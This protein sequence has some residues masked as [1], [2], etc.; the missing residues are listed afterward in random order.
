MITIS[1]RVA[2][3]R[4]PGMSA[5]LNAGLRA[6]VQDTGGEVRDGAKARS[7]VDT[8]EMRAGWE[9]HMTGDLSGEVSN[10]VPHTIYNEYGTVH[11]SAQPMAHPAADAAT[12][13]FVAGVRAVLGEL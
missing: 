8:G 10:P 12:P 7:R 3:N 6:Q 9:F 13:G 11:M 5:K 4:F 1:V 2:S